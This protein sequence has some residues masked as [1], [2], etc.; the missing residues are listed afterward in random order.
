MKESN[1]QTMF[2]KFTRG[3]PPHASAVYELKL[4]KGTSIAFDKVKEHQIDALRKAKSEG[5]YHKISDAPFGHSEGFRF[6][7]PRPLDCLFIAK[8]EAYVVVL[9]YKPRRK[10]E[11]IFI[12]IEAWMKE[13]SRSERKS[14]T[15]ERA[16]AISSKIELIV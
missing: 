5:F 8:P 13:K 11:A 4:E 9:F 12:D 14:L 2:S 16:K 15:E 1:F 6:H 7:V 3:N 10:K